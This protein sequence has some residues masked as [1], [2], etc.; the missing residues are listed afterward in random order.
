MIG[1][2]FEPALRGEIAVL[3]LGGGRRVPLH[4]GRW[5]ADADHADELMLGNC[6]GPAIDVGCGPGRLV[7][8]LTR[9]GVPAIGVDISPVAV[10]LARAR[11][12]L[13]LRRDV[14]GRVPGEGRWR[15]VLLADGNIGIGGDP[16]A[17]L[18]RCRELL[19]PAGGSVLVEVDPPGIGLHTEPARVGPLGTWFRWA[20]LGLDALGAVAADAGFSVRWTGDRAG[21][22]FA[23]LETDVTSRAWTSRAAV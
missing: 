20:W 10:A 17:L 18:R 13:A 19:I 12:A 1:T 16:V 9:R 7:D 8:A 6:R 22:W 15:H 4:P 21:R 5:L 23:E 2:E 11:G 3:E 14:F